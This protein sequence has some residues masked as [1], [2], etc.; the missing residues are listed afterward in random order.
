MVGALSAAQMP[1]TAPTRCSRSVGN[2]AMAI[3]GTGNRLNKMKSIICGE[4]SW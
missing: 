4:F 1:A 2:S 3:E